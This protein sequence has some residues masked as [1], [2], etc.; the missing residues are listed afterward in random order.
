VVFLDQ[1]HDQSFLLGCHPAADDCLAPGGQ[2]CEGM[3]PPHLRTLMGVRGL[4]L[5]GGHWGPKIPKELGDSPGLEEVPPHWAWL[6]PSLIC[7]C[8]SDQGTGLIV[9][10]QQ[11]LIL[12]GG[13]G[14]VI[15]PASSSTVHS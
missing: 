4:G 15:Q 14:S 6:M 5:H 7:H 3:F 1:C 13:K 12:D 11:Q 2:V 8:I 10:R 9:Q